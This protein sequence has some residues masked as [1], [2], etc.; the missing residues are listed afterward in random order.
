MTKL[1]GCS[2]KR[3]IKEILESGP[4]TITEWYPSE[5]K[6]RQGRQRKQWE[7]KI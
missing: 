5:N 6:N 1:K 3:I 7:D 4:E 2:A